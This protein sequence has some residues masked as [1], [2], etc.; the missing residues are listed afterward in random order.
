[1]GDGSGWVLVS[2]L[3]PLMPCFGVEG[4]GVVVVVG[5]ILRV[6]VTAVE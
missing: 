6:D 2:F 5:V 4:G 1:M 3:L